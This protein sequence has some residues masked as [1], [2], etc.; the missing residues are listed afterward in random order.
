[1]LI[2]LANYFFISRTLILALLDFQNSLSF[3]KGPTKLKGF[4]GVKECFTNSIAISAQPALGLAVTLPQT[5][6][7]RFR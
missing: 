7:P 5:L 4:Q 6:P 2:L 1:M 3:N